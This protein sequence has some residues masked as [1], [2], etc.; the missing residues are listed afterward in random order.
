MS[1]FNAGERVRLTGHRE[2]PDGTS[3]TISA[4]PEVLIEVWGAERSGIRRL[5]RAGSRRV[6]SFYVVFDNPTDDGSGDG[7]YS[8]AE[9]D[10]RYL[11]R[12]AHE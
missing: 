10:S 9:I 2:F 5:H 12:I 6:T 1:D 8:G 11:V 3:G 4:P 7:P